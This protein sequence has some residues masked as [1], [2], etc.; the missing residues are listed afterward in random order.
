MT[1]S[2]GGRPVVLVADDDA[3]VRDTT[4]AMLHSGGFEVLLAASAAQAILLC[5]TQ[6]PWV[7]VLLTDLDMPGVSGS[8]LA[9]AVTMLDA[10]PVIVYMS[11]TPRDIAINRGWITD[12]ALL[13]AKPFSGAVLIATLN[14]ALRRVPD[15]S[16]GS[17]SAVGAT[18]GRLWSGRGGRHQRGRHTSGRA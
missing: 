7:D 8:E 18:L 17:A 16:R 1:G 11:G 13:L 6:V 14:S 10:A 15:G 9:R 12:G 5:R 4:G 3:D 2:A